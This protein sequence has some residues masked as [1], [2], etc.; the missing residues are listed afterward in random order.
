MAGPV[1]VAHVFVACLH[2]EPLRPVTTYSHRTLEGV[3]YVYQTSPRGAFPYQADIH[4]F[5][6]LAYR[7]RRREFHQMLN[8]SVVWL[9]DP[10]GCSGGLARNFHD[11]HFQPWVPVKDISASVDC[12]FNGPGRYEFRLW[13]DAGSKWD[14]SPRRRNVARTYLRIEG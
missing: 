13:Y 6:R 14:G 10:A 12:V 2:V 8:V 4:L 9:D 5:V 3:C 11:L 1:V 7:W